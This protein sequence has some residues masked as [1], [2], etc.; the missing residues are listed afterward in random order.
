MEKSFDNEEELRISIK[1][2]VMKACLKWRSMLGWVIVL[3]VLA[4]GVAVYKDSNAQKQIISQN[5][6]TETE[7][8]EAR[9]NS[10]Q[11]SMN[12]KKALL[13]E[14]EIEEVERSYNTYLTL[15]TRY[16]NAIEYNSESLL[17][18]LNPSSIPT[19]TLSYFVDSHYEA[20]YP[21]VETLDKTPDI[22]EAIE[23]CITSDETCAEMA[24]ALGLECN[25]SYVSELIWFGDENEVLTVSIFGLSQSDCETMAAVIKDAINKNLSNIKKHFGDFEISLT[26]EGYAESVNREVLLEQTTQANNLNLVKNA[27]NNLY[28][29]FTEKQRNYY[30][31]LLDYS[32]V[33]CDQA[34][35]LNSEEATENTGVPGNISLIHIKMLIVGALLGFFFF[36]C[37]VSLQYLFT[38]KIR[39]KRDVEEFSHLPV[40]GVVSPK[41][42][43]AIDRFIK[44][45]FGESAKI[46][47]DDQMDLICT[48]L[49]IIARE[50]NAKNIFLA[51]SCNDKLI[52]DIA[53]TIIKQ[54]KKEQVTI[55][56]GADIL[57]NPK[58]LEQ[59]AASDGVVYVEQLSKTEYYD[60]RKESNKAKTYNVPVWGCV[61]LD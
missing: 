10:L 47:L 53:E 12:E 27:F 58:G 57:N 3:A 17:M 45:V 43:G 6:M 55:R 54:L 30:Y 61:L 34:D 51:S 37:F 48:E 26:E 36:F 52:D 16:E 22:I 33:L 24:G 31:A 1:D 35:S 4:N 25:T 13:T 40:L 39:T 38:T 9:L 59:L 5:N 44:G 15:Q 49:K 19:V 7:R 56:S 18:K 42:I 14:R 11:R 46:S 21:V 32:K 28:S 29:S 20:V 2:W 23:A 41:K 8:Y 60:L 50:R